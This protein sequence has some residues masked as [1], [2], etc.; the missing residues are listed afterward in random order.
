MYS[1]NYKAFMK[2][3]KTIQANG[4]IHCAH[5]LEKLILFKRSG[6]PRQSTDSM[7]FLSKSLPDFFFMTFLKSLWNRI[8]NSGN[9][10]WYKGKFL[11][12]ISSSGTVELKCLDGFSHTLKQLELFFFFFFFFTHLY[13]EP[14]QRPLLPVP[15][16]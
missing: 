1:E 3:L 11:C 13:I 7:Q 12:C 10:S 9:D 4:K 15:Q 5:R 2:K 6:Y 8:Q 16:S 14:L